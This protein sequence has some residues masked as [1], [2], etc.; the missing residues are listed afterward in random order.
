MTTA[1]GPRR[2][3]VRMDLLNAWLLHAA[4]QLWL[5][6]VLLVFFFIDGFAT[7]LPSE[8]ALVALAALS[9]HNGEPNLLVLGIV[10]L[11]GAVAGDNMAYLLGSTIGTERWAW[12]RRPRVHKMFEWA[13]YELDKRGAALIFTAR[14]IPWGRVAV[15]YMAGQTGY[16]HRRFFLFDLFA[17]LTWVAYALGIGLLAGQWVH[18][19]PLLGVGIAVVF[20]VILGFGIDHVL[21]WW[22]RRRGDAE[23]ARP[24]SAREGVSPTAATGE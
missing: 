4:G 24:G 1:P 3:V 6:P 9:L 15:N 23:P 22:H 11:V 14:Y 17:C 2:S 13:R 10:A 18:D 8:T 19:N 20:A 7:I 5:F 12:M 16:P 21:R